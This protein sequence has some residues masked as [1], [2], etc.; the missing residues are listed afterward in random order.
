MTL[1]RS[2]LKLCSK[3]KCNILINVLYRPPSGL[4]L[5]L[6]N[7]LKDVFKKTKNF[8]KMLH[9]A[10]EFN[11]DLLDYENCK[12]A[13]EFLNLAYENNMIQTINKPT[14]VTR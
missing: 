3:K 9:I 2:T 1:S 12:K 7:F 8:N 14:R 13:E 11:M 6:E 4:I 5:P 10:G